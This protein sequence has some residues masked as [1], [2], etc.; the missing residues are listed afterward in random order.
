MLSGMD[1]QRQRR[2][3]AF[4][5]LDKTILAGSSTLAFGRPLYENG[6]INR[7]LV[8]RSAYARCIFRLQG[9]GHRRMERMRSELSRLVRG[10]DVDRLRNVIG[11]SVQ[12]AI[13]PMIYA[14]AAALIA[15][16]RA[17]GRDVILVSSSG[18]DIVEPVGELLGIEDVIATRMVV[19]EGAYT[20]EIEF[21]AYAEAKAQVIHELAAERGYDLEECFGYSDSITDRPLLEA[22]GKPH[23]V[24]P[25]RA[26]RKVAIA[27]GWPILDFEA[28]VNSRGQAFRR[29]AKTSGGRTLTVVAGLGAA[30]ATALF[31]TRQG[32]TSGGSRRRRLR[33]AGRKG[34]D[35]G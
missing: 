23:A 35:L 14:E 27:S 4:F 9:A 13:V 26:L 2:S 17:A 24:N 12:Q 16:H 11:C 5:D 28:P 20:G 19:D 30:A 22:V 18:S 6:F 25:D 34:K 33:D 8:V 15:E 7:R 32:R 31:W 10:W 21:Y 29:T 1:G 3:A